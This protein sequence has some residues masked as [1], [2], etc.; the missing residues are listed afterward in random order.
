MVQCCLDAD[1]YEVLS[2]AFRLAKVASDMTVGTYM[3]VR[4]LFACGG[5]LAVIFLAEIIHPDSMKPL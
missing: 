5:L 2:L 1:N 4:C 3:D